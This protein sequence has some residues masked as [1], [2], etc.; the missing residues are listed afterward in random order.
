MSSPKNGRTPR[1][2]WEQTAL[3][4][5][6]YPANLAFAGV[7]GFILAIP[8]VTALPAAVA[9]ARSMDDWLREDS[10]TVFTSTFRQFAATWR[11]TLP[12]GVLAFVV[13]AILIVDVLFLANQIASGTSGLALALGAATVPVAVSVALMLLAVPVAASR[14]RDG[15]ARQWL[16]EAGYLVTSRP[17]RATIL[18]VLSVAVALTCALLPTLIPFFGLSLP[19]FLALT[20]LGPP[21][22]AAPPPPTPRPRPR[23]PRRPDGEG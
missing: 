2:G 8:L 22:P 16:I 10:T 18:L 12:L 21:A 3:S 1:R 4:A 7:A 23:R 14:N 9:A 17:L 11:R 20:S 5:L 6:T 15:T 19:V 13:V